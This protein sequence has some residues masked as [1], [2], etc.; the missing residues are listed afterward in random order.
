MMTRGMWNIGLRVILAVALMAAVVFGCA[1]R[2]DLPFAWAYVAVQGGAMGAAATLLDRDLLRERLRPGPGGI[3]R[4]LRFVVM[5]FFT[6]H[7]VVAGLD[8]G[9]YQWSGRMAIGIQIAA[10]VGLAA[11]VTLSV[12]AASVN[13]FF[14][15]VVRIQAERGHSVVT[16]GP[17]QWIRHPGYAATL[18]STLCSGLVLGSWWSM[19]PLAPLPLLILRRTIIED[20]Y[21][22]ERLEGY[23]D[24]AE[25]VR[26]RLIPGVW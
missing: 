16:S 5:P 3:D 4:G 9:R 15:P 23:A 12:W 10:V 18:G 11:S 7:L 8:I 17:Y 25:R 22:R 1:G 6:T 13:R 2:W 19:L 14:S 20:W 21:L 26:Y 24:Y